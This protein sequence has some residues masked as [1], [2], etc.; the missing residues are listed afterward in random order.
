[1]VAMKYEDL[2]RKAAAFH[3]D[4]CVGQVLGVRMVM[5]G[6][7]RLDIDDPLKTRDLIIFVEVDRCL[8][9]AIQATTGCTLGKRRIKFVNYGKFGA[10]FL[11]MSKKKAVRVSVREKARSL[12]RRYAEE[13]GWVK[14]GE[15]PEWK[16]W[17][18]IMSKVYSKMR[19]R[20]LLSIRRVSVEISK[21][22]LPGRPK[23]TVECKMCGELIYDHREVVRDG[24]T[25]CKPCAEGAYYKP[26]DSTRSM[27]R[28][29]RSQF[30][31]TDLAISSI[32]LKFSKISSARTSII[33]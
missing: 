19:E 2:I 14:Q 7:R 18:E 31:L 32:F 10:T 22:D 4:I 33:L 13:K 15:E 12:A 30:L 25:L 5:A 9:D 24:R 23:H 28:Y 20:D 11:D 3:G 8:A 21:W 6:L 1:M 27:V 16:K 17:M 29:W 26:R